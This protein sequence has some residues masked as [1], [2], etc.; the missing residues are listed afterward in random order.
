M[1]RGK[2]G[3]VCLVR[4][5]DDGEPALA[6][7]VREQLHD[8]VAARA[9][10]VAG[11]LVGDE[12]H[13]VGDDGAGDRHALLLAAGEFAGVWSSRPSSPTWPSAFMAMSRRSRPETPR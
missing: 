6:V 4:D 13:R 10:E 5:H 8:L 9:V 1:R 12:E 2:G 11:R 3:D 7:E